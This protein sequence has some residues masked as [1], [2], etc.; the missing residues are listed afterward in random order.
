VQLTVVLLLSLAATS[1]I[2]TF[3]PQNES[4]EAYFKAYG[5]FLYRL[6][7]VLDIFDMYHA[8]WFQSLVILLTVNIIVCS[9]DRL[10]ATWNIIFVKNPSFKAARFRKRAGRREFSDPRPPGELKTVCETLASRKFGRV[11]TEPSGDGFCVFGERWRWSRLGVYIVHTSIVVLLIGG[12]VGS[13]FGFDGY[14]NIPEGE[15]VD[16]IR[17]RGNNKAIRLPFGIRCN[18]FDVS[19]Y[20]TGQPKEFRSSLSLIKD[21][22]AVMEKEIIVNDPLRYQGI[23]IFQA[24]YGQMDSAPAAANPSPPTDITLVFAG[25]ESGAVYEEE[26]ELGREIILPEGNGTFVLKEYRPTAEFRGQSIGGALMGIRTRDGQKPVTVMLPLRFP[27]FDRMRKGDFVISVAGYK[28]DQS[29]QGAGQPTG[30]RYFT[31]LQVTNDPGVWMVYTGFVLMIV[32]CFVTFFMSHQQ[33]CIEVGPGG[34]G[35]RI[36]VAGISNRNRVAMQNLVEGISKTLA[37][38]DG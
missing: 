33:L 2:G 35:S 18:D 14:V 30:K 10:S 1:I 3:I 34:K 24:S 26:A 21:G 12:L 22:K 16:Q 38:G 29:A 7:D 27:K 28:Q 15:T 11:R 20:N 8:W 6:F 31:G 37:A 25:R 23:N 4:P 19:F 9:I 36:L 32:G 13:M 17:L 5:E